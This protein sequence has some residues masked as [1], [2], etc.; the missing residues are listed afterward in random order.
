MKKRLV[1]SVLLGAMVISTLTGCGTSQQEISQL[2]SLQALNTDASVTDSYSL[3]YTDEQNLIYAQVTDRTLLDLSSLEV[4][5]EDELQQVVS[6]MNTVDQQLTGTAEPSNDVIDERFTDY[7]LAQFE[8]T[9][10]YWQRTNMQVRGIDAESRSI[11]VD[12]KYDTIEYKKDV[13]EKSFIPKGSPDYD[14]LTQVRYEKYCNIL[15]KKFLNSSDTWKA[16]LTKFEQVYGKI[17]DIYDSQSNYGLTDNVYQTGNQKTYTGLVD[18]DEE[19]TGASMTVR[20]ILVPKYVLGINLGLTCKHMYV[21]DYSLNE[22]PT[23]DRKLFKD[24]GYATV[25]DSVYALI[26]SYFNCIDESDYNGL[27]KLTD[28]FGDLD[29]YYE[30]MFDTTYTKHN[31]FTLSVFNIQGTQI[32]CGVTASIHTRARGSDMTY[33]TY[34]DR[35]YLKLELVDGELKVIND[36][37]LSRKIEGEPAITTNDADTSG[38]VASIDLDNEARQ[39]IEKLI[40]DFGA[41]Q[42]NKETTSDAFGDVVDISMATSDLTQLQ[43]NMTSLTGKEK[44]VFLMNYQQGTSNYA[45]VKC[46]EMFQAKDNSIVEA[47]TTYSFMLKGGKWY[48]Y[49]Y[50]INSTVKLDTTNL[51]T[52]GC[53]ALIS[54]GRVE[55]YTSQVQATTD[56]S[57]DNK[58]DITVKYDYEHY[59]PAKKNGVNQQGFAKKTADNVSD[60]DMTTMLKELDSF[61]TPDA[62]VVHSN[63]LQLVSAGYAT[64]ENAENLYQVMKEA[65]AIIYNCT[66][67]LY[68]DK[69]E[70]QKAITA[71]DTD[72]LKVCINVTS[73]IYKNANGSAQESF[74]EE[75]KNGFKNLETKVTSL[76]TN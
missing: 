60:S 10:Y 1:S 2:N 6:Y 14:K 76:S 29:K 42:L 36:V 21:T 59:K 16:D 4:C 30:D 50:D 46:K 73:D 51:N 41:L 22:D 71:F 5:T 52:T 65:N 49:Q 45:S 20:Y 38:F 56:T 40:C 26:Y 72:K 19:Q 57:K 69:L 63:I 54:P 23:K 24:E 53:L 34:T 31:N 37:L 18:S 61:T 47:E 74:A 28:S 43:T 9:P 11:I 44:V 17:K 13:K 7:L 32:E 48:I 25:T 70:K 64:N 62:T 68:N 35:Y 58:S 66:H 12:V 27:Y 15:S 67:N 39:S 3:S 75:L 8:Q 33:P 55:S